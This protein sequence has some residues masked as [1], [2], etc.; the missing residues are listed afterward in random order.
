MELSF[1]TVDKFCDDV[2]SSVAHPVV[3]LSQVTFFR[4]FAPVYLGMFL[5]HH[6]ALGKS[7]QVTTPIDPRARTY[8][9][10]QNFWQRFNFNPEVIEGERLYRFTT[11]TSLN[12]FLI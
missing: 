3:N 12:E 4:P 1:W 6:N 5:R 9:A 11:Q 2:D 7:F 8:I 10:R